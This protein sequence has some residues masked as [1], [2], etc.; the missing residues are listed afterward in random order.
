M[1]LFVSAAVALASVTA[2]PAFA[3]EGPYGQLSIY[4]TSV[5]DDDISV[6]PAAP[7]AAIPVSND[8]ALGFS[9]ALGYKLPY[10]LRA[11]AEASY[12][13]NNNVLA[14]PT[15]PGTAFLDGTVKSFAGMA[16]GYV[17]IP[18]GT[19]VTPYVGAGVGMA[20]VD[21]DGAETLFAYQG[22]AGISLDVSPQTSFVLGYKYFAS[23]DLKGSDPTIG[24]LET[25]YATHN[26]ELGLRYQFD[27]PV[28]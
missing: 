17:D 28:N 15:L 13:D 27:T 18:T 6:T 26:I 11:E 16:N 24:S 21:M 3:A 5:Q 2:A 19:V 23:E 9:A 10:N 20:R 14:V 8:S 22:M 25:P 1:K 7:I 4:H 12:R